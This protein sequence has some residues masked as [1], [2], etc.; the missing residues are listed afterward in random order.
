MSAARPAERG[1][2]RDDGPTLL[3]ELDLHLFNEG[4]H[5]HLH[6]HLG[7]HVIEHRGVTGTYFAVW[8]PGAESVGVMGDWSHWQPS[9]LAPRGTS[10]IWEGFVAGVNEGQRYKYAVQPRHGGPR[11]EKADPYGAWHEVAPATASVVWN[12]AYTWGDSAWMASREDR[13]ALTAPVS[14]YEVHLGS[15]RRVPEEGNR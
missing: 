9:P 3:G 7:A 13:L 1:P 14:I 5:A 6:D 12:G 11:L 15:W 10:G 2:R 8:A 4:T